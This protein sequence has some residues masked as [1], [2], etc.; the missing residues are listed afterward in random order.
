[1]QYLVAVPCRD[2]RSPTTVSEL[3]AL[4]AALANAGNL[5]TQHL[6]STSAP[7]D[8]K[9]KRLVLYLFSQPM[10]LF[11]ALALIAGFVF[12]AIALHIGALSIVQPL[13]VAE[14]VFA[15]L[16]RRLWFHHR[17][18]AAA[19]WS[20]V[21]TCAGLG[22]FI[23]ASEPDGGRMTA[24]TSEWFSASLVLG[25]IA[26]LMT[27]AARWGTPTAKAA[28]YGTATGVVWALEAS[29]IKSMTDVLAQYG[30]FRMFLHWPVYA[31]IVGGILG[32]ILMQAALHVGPLNVSSPL[33]VA[34][35]PVVSVALGVWLF[36]EEFTDDPL[37]IAL[38]AAG[39]LVLALGIWL[40]T[41]Y[42]PTE[43]EVPTPAV[44][45]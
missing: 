45:A 12:Q 29:F 1:V 30:L 31:V 38:S 21:I 35:D 7:E 43:D 17:I 8:V 23:V 39:F 33:M 20:A 24:S 14:L 6:S 25:G 36:A 26:F 15:L 18:S 10:W 44:G 4:L 5:V 9:G 32:N 42:A 41:R 22:V 34:T 13:M 40:M 11:G 28:L 37:R 16:I 27:V 19:W 3:F 2:A